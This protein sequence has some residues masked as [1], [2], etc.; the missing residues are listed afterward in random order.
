MPEPEFPDKGIIWRGWDTETVALIAEKQRPVL[1]F[2]ADPI[3]PEWPFLREIFKEMP[4]NE[5]LR[6]LLHES[7]LPLFVEGNAAPDELSRLGAGSNHFIAVLSPYGLT[8]MVTINPVGDP[9]KI[10][11][12]I[13][14]I[15]ERLDEGWS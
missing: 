12:Q 7:F 11:A 10:V 15:L 13:V 1:L 8:P 14:S 2:V 4:A 6:T 9:A 3:A 5:R